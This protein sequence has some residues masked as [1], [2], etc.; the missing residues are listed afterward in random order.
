MLSWTSSSIQSSEP[1]KLCLNRNEPN[2]PDTEALNG[3]YELPGVV[4]A[5]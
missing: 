3:Q 2:R 5:K 1:M 4:L